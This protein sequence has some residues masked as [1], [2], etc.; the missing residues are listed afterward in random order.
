MAKRL[1]DWEKY[2]QEFI[3]SGFSEIKEFFANSYPEVKFNSFKRHTTG[4]KE[5]RIA[6][7]ELQA[8]EGKKEAAKDPEVK[9]L[10]VSLIKGKSVALKLV[11]NKLGKDNRE[12]L[13]IRDLKEIIDIVRRELGEAHV[14]TDN[15]IEGK[16][17][18][19]AF[20][21]NLKNLSTSEI[22]KLAELTEKLQPKT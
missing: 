3:S 9:D 14:I 8:E 22:L 2:K 20:D 11:L 17:D 16:G 4:W 12:S 6:Y 15:K 10:T 1:Y 7:R 5:A 18:D 21:I 13:S 19:G